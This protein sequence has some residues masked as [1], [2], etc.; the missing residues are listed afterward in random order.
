MPPEGRLAASVVASLP[1]FRDGELPTGGAK[2]EDLISGWRVLRRTG[3]ATLSA[4]VCILGVAPVIADEPILA[5]CD[6]LFGGD[7]DGEN[8]YAERI[9][10]ERHDFT[11]SAVTVGRG[12]IQIESGYTFFYHDVDGAT[13]T[14][15]TAPEMLL[16]LGLSEGIEFRIRW[17]YVWVAIEDEP[18]ES[19][20]GGLAPFAQAAADRSRV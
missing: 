14:A 9:E 3:F 12:V 4:A 19:G 8:P 1:I 6:D 7:C 5:F 17:N 15:H 2:G 18:D 13:E 11:Q 16:R 20:A 10:T